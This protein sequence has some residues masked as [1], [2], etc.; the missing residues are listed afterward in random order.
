MI[1]EIKSGDTANLKS[2]GQ[3]Y[4]MNDRKINFGKVI[5]MLYFILLTH[6]LNAQAFKNEYEA[7]IFI[8]EHNITDSI[9]G[10]WSLTSSMEIYD[11]DVF[12]KKVDQDEHTK[13]IIIFIKADSIYCL[14]IDGTDF[15]S[16]FEK[17]AIK[18]QYIYSEAFVDKTIS[19]TA[20]LT[21]NVMTIK[22]FLPQ[23]ITTELLG[24][25][26]KSKKLRHNLVLIKL[27]PY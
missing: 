21:Q 15:G 20:Y 6:I 17:T 24:E 26:G 18:N 13:R 23:E 7:K 12:I 27:F 8:K 3:N 14:N 10:I 5:T 2:G 19:A 22:Y 4:I 9:E 11:S 16:V 1:K 25:E